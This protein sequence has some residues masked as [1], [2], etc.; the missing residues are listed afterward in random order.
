MTCTL[1]HII[2]LWYIFY[3]TLRSTDAGPFILVNNLPQGVG[4]PVIQYSMNA[5]LLSQPLALWL[6]GAV[7]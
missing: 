6:S 1:L 2:E 3:N 4:G 7:L 5:L